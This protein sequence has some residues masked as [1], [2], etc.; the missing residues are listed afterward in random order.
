MGSREESSA[1]A[2]NSEIESLRANENVYQEII[3]LFSA[4]APSSLNTEFSIEDENRKVIL[5]AVRSQQDIL[6][7]PLTESVDFSGQ[8]MQI[9]FKRWN[10]KKEADGLEVSAEWLLE[11]QG[12]SK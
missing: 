9:I 8:I 12:F 10:D 4:I 3:N 6:E 5:G 11:N 2:M 1:P 7:S